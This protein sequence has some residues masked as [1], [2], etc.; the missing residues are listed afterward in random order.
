MD[1]PAASVVYAAA[2]RGE[3]FGTE[4]GHSAA[5]ADGA[6][7]VMLGV[8]FFVAGMVAAFALT[9]RRRARR[10]DPTLQFLAQLADEEKSATPQ[11]ARATAGESWERPPDWWKRED[12]R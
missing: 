4:H 9:M 3:G 7:L 10:P 8:V 11:E 6:A 5:A 1:V 12:D 2:L